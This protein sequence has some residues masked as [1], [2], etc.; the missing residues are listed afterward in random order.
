MPR[1]ERQWLLQQFPH[2]PWNGFVAQKIIV[3]KSDAYPTGQNARLNFRAVEDYD[4]DDH[5]LVPKEGKRNQELI[6]GW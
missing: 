2:Y 4:D 3:N 1:A 5:G 6:N